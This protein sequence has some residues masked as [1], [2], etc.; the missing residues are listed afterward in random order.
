MASVVLQDGIISMAT[1]FTQ[2]WLS[3]EIGIA[4]TT[5]HLSGVAMAIL[6]M[7]CPSNSFDLA[8]SRSC[9]KIFFLCA[10]PSI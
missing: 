4:F 5:W 8:F 6:D 2:E 3:S 1:S 7:P 9:N 10:F